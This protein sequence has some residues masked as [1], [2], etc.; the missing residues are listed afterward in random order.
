MLRNRLNNLIDE[1]TLFL[2]HGDNFINEIS[3]LSLIKNISS[4]TIIIDNTSYKFEPSSIKLAYKTMGV[5]IGFTIRD[6]FIL[7]SDFTVDYWINL[8]SDKWY[9]NNY[10][11]YAGINGV[12]L[13]GIFIYDSTQAIIRY[14]DSNNIIKNELVPFNYIV[15]EWIHIAIVRKG[16]KLYPFI[17]GHKYT[18]SDGSEF[19]INENL[20]IDASSITY[21]ARCT[22]TSTIN[23]RIDEIRI[24]NVARWTESFTPPTKPYK[25]KPNK[26]PVLVTLRFFPAGTYNYTFPKDVNKVDVFLV[27]GGGG[28]TNTGGVHKSGGGGGYTKTY[29]GSDYV[30]PSSGTWVY[31]SNLILTSGRDGNAIDITP[32]EEVEIIVGEGGSLADGGYSQFKNES[33]RANGGIFPTY[34]RNT[35]YGLMYDGGN[36]GSGGGAAR[37][38]GG[39]DGSDGVTWDEITYAGVGQGHTTRD[40]GL[41]TN[42]INAGG[43]SGEGTY[44]SPHTGTAGYE[45]GKGDD[46][47]TYGAGGGGYGGGG[48]G[49]N[50]TP[51]KGGDGTVLVR[52]YTRYPPIDYVDADTPIVISQ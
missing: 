24:S 9:Y 11:K 20:H 29:R 6:T 48:A 21:N 45:E 33:Y 12:N 3:G 31:D 8:S 38:H 43:G 51:T 10:N 37:Q 14:T 32:N 22:L 1:H 23:N 2:N 41:I 26:Y 25:I 50:G 46:G 4:S 13:P 19:L 17:N 42:N 28:G 30:A 16:N 7:D 36:G 15:N 39:E 40:F 49:A 52:F 34:T 27:G 47:D 5:V 18:S 35:Q 44:E